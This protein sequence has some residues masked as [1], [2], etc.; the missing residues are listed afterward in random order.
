MKLKLVHFLQPGNGRPGKTHV[1][2]RILEGFFMWACKTRVRAYSEMEYDYNTDTGRKVW[3]TEEVG[4]GDLSDVV[5]AEDDSVSLG[6]KE[7]VFGGS[8]ET[9]GVEITCRY[10]QRWLKRALIREFR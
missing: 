1:L 10:C 5:I 3:N 2:W 8:V 6:V 9:Y 4:D 7:K